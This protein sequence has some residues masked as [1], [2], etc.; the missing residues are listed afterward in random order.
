VLKEFSGQR[1]D[2]DQQYGT[3][4]RE[5][6]SRIVDKIVSRIVVRMREGVSDAGN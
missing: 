2:I 3:I 1:C 5:I 6:D 4:S